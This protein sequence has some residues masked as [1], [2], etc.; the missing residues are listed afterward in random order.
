MPS[1]SQLKDL[2]HCVS[3]ETKLFKILAAKFSVIFGMLFNY[4]FHKTKNLLTFK[5]V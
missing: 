5:I 2:S 1:L 4:K 3:L